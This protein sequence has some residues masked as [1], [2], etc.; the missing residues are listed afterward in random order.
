MKSVILVL[1][2]NLETAKEFDTVKEA[3]DAVKEQGYDNFSYVDIFTLYTSARF[4]VIW[5]LA[6]DTGTNLR[7]VKKQE[8]T[9]TT[10]RKGGWSDREVKT[11]IDSYDV[12][13]STGEIAKALHRTPGAVYQK[14][15]K[16]GIKGKGAPAP[17]KSAKDLGKDQVTNW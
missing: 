11:L 15:V 17:K 7:E 5:E 10:T 2:Q 12:G 9:S 8:A 4:E 16:L 3:Q 14:A 1:D 6:K 13:M